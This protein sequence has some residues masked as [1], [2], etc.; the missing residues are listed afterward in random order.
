MRSMRGVRPVRSRR[1]VPVKEAFDALSIAR[2][3]WQGVRYLKGLVNSEALTHDVVGFVAPTDSTSATSNNVLLNGIAQGDN[4]GQRTGNSLLMKRIDIKGY[5]QMN[6][7]AT[8]VQGVRIALVLDTQQISD[9][10]TIGF[11]DVFEATQP[12]TSFM[13]DSQLGRFTV[14]WD[15]TFHVTEVNGNFRVPYKISVPL[16]LHVRYNGTAATD[17]QK[18]GMW[19]ITVS[20]AS[21][22]YPTVVY[23]SRLRY[24]DN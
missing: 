13:Q 11:E 2:S 23:N 24:H 16:G 9:D 10:S 14:L 7:T 8:D 3:A 15:R 4:I 21:A 1:G 17:L 6:G 22:N 5:V 19:L 12:L 20:D 18:H